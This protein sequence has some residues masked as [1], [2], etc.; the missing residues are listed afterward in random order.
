MLPQYFVSFCAGSLFVWFV[1][2]VLLFL[3]YYIFF[4]S[5]KKK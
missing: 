4:L 3:I 5:A 1:V 2:P